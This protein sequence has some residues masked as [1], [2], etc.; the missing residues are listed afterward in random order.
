MVELPLEIIH[1]IIAVSLPHSSRE[2]RDRQKFLLPLCHVHS[3]LRRFVQRLLFSHVI[4]KSSVDLAYFL[5][6]VEGLPSEFDFGSCVQSFELVGRGDE[7]DG[8]LR[9][10]IGRCKEIKEVRIT[11]VNKI[12]LAHFSRLSSEYFQPMYNISAD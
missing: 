5:D 9:R 8:Y 1:N 10:I 4:L 12:N 7:A 3:S 2:N 11:S 6:A